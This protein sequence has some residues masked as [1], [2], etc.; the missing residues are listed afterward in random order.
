MSAT[1]RRRFAPASPGAVRFAD[2]FWRTWTER[3][4]KIT[5]PA[6]HRR[7]E[8]EG[9]LEAL[10]FGE[11]PG[12]LVRPIKPSGLSMQH[13]FDSDVGKWIE[14]ASYTLMGRRDAALEARIDA[15]VE[16][17]A[18]GQMADGYLNSWFIRREPEGRW[19]NL[20]DLHEMYSLGHLLEGALAYAQAT[21]KTRFL[22][23]VRRAV[24]HVAERF[25]PGPGQSRGYDAHAEIE[26][27][28]LR[29][30]R[31]TGDAQALKLAAFLVDERGRQPSFFDAEALARGD[32]PAAYV[33]KTYAY[34]QAH[35]PVREQDEVV[36]HAV[37]A[38]YLFTAMADLAAE[39]GDA[40]LK[41]ACDRLFAQLTTRRLYVTGGLGP[42]AANEGFT[43]DYDLPNASAYAETCAAIGLALWCRSL[44]A[45]DLDARHADLAETVMLNGALAGLSAAGDRFFYDNP[46]ESEG[47]HRRWAWHECPC[48]TGNI[49]RFVASAGSSF[50]AV[51]E[52]EI[53]VHHYGAGEARLGLGG[54]AVTIAQETRYPWDGEV[55]LLVSPARPRRFVLH[56]RLPG[57]CRSPA[58][59]LNGEPLDCGAA[60][61]GYLSIERDWREG[62]ALR[63]SLPMAVECLHAH[64]AV[65]ADAGRVALRRG[66]VVYCVEQAD[67]A[68]PPQRLSLPASAPLV[69]RFDPGLLGGAVVIEGE[70]L[71]D[72]DGEWGDALYRTAAPDKRTVAFRAIPYHLWANRE[73]GAMQVWLRE[74]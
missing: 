48:C 30:H 1:P 12:P 59:A 16:A 58:L 18:G 17:Y 10:A 50:Y 2:G 5:V 53:A 65:A 69:A 73:P 11:P 4:R 15:I 32:D 21:G 25:G 40:A 3:V 67:V 46:L 6:I 31:A 13:F 24:A 22:D 49:A 55:T 74:A 42:S 70:A 66:P 43:R 71:A 37:R 26:L 51:G 28:L 68:V 39:T 9:V 56:V 14:A 47:G 52:G 41:A 38:M 33:Y 64:P 61:R 72:T 29:L 63:L 44:S 57:W 45:M 20:R 19:T 62:D 23:V 7:L 34:S 27:A 36:G 60:R 35:R 8:E 54:D